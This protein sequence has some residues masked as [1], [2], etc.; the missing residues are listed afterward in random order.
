MREPRIRTWGRGALAFGASVAYGAG[1]WASSPLWAGHTEPWDGP[2]GVYVLLVTAGGL[3]SLIAPRMLMA[4]PAGLVI[5]QGG[6]MMLALPLGPLFPIGLATLCIL[7]GPAVGIACLVY[8]ADARAKR[9][10]PAW[11][12]PSCGYDMRGLRGGP[13]PECGATVL[14]VRSGVAGPGPTVGPP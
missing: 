7:A 8:L 11:M 1:L 10:Q 3:L 9:R 5:G 13:C 14:P 2:F 12:C 6:Y 4:A